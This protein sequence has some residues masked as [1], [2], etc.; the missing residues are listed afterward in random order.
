MSPSA[1]IRHNT[2][3]GLFYTKRPEILR[4]ELA[5]M[6]NAAEKM[7]VP[8]RVLGIIAPHAGYMY[9]GPTAAAAYAQ[10]VGEKYDTVVIVSP[11]HH[12]FFEGVSVF[13]GELY[14]T[15]LGQVRI[16]APLRTQALAAG[17]VL[18]PTEAGHRQEHAIEVQLPFLQYAL[19]DFL[20]LPLVVGHQTRDA[21]FS[22][23]ETLTEVLR[24]KNALLV[25]STDLSH[26]Y[27]A[28]VARRLD[29]VA[30]EDIRK[31]DPV[32]FMDHLDQGLAEACGG[33]PAVSVMMALQGLG[34]TRMDVVAHC[35]SGDVTGET[36]SVV[37]YLS[38]VAWS[39]PVQST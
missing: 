38:A 10:V 11:S 13:P 39:S 17:R 33:G 12:E 2:V 23:A 32:Q 21:C 35:N 24:D 4:K 22:L 1:S 29:T 36:E 26:Y 15:P 25:A 5:E 27:P 6:F 9:S 20:L 28:A 37:G 16:D 31:F 34:A 14:E 3:A 30:A 18:R 19:G 7:T 8:G